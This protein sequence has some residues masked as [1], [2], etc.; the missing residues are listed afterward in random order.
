MAKYRININIM[1]QK[2]AEGCLQALEV[3]NFK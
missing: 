1:Q 3:Q 2:C